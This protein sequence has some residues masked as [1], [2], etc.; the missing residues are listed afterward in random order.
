MKMPRERLEP[1]E[2]PDRIR[3][4][5]AGTCSSAELFEEA[6]G[7]QHWAPGT[8]RL[9]ER[10]LGLYLGFL[11][12]RRWL[13]K[14]LGPEDLLNV[15]WLKGYAEFCAERMLRPATKVTRFNMLN[16]ALRVMAP[17]ADRTTLVQVLRRLQKAQ[18]AQPK[19]AASSVSSS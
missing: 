7:A 10:G 4:A 3:A 14:D 13:L 2:W 17:L 12:M 6:G 16:E 18:R 1:P 5:W 15:G 11:S 8:R 9:V 19:S